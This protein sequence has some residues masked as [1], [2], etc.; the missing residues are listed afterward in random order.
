MSAQSVARLAEAASLRGMLVGT[1]AYWLF[2]GHDALV[3]SVASDILVPQLLFIRSFVI[4]LG[5]LAIGRRRLLAQFM[6]SRTRHMMA[7]R[8]LLTLSAWCMYY[9]MSPH[10]QLAEMTTLYYV[11]PI[12]T[13]VLAVFFLKE[14]LTTA[15]VAAASLGFFGVLVACN[16]ADM[17]IGL[18][19]LLVLGAAF[20][21]SVAMILMRTISKSE[22]ALLQIFVINAI[23]TVIMGLVA[24]FMWR[25]MDLRQFAVIVATGLVGG[26][27]QY[28]LVEAAR[29]VPASVLGTVEYS[30]LLWSFVFGYLFWGEVP[31]G[32]VYLGAALIMLAGLLLA[33][34]ERRKRREFVEAP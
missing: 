27:G 29:E 34:N 15:R 11:A 24:I 3:K 1:A 17:G 18:P 23:F 7:Y 30:A 6:A 28:A 31:D 16:P 8:A 10:M 9:S 2:A 25:A 22:S 5:C 33:W 12:M 13:T 26:L 20:L 21:W 14:R 4:V 19:A 32:T